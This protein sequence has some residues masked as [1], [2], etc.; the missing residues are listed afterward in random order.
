M[1]YTIWKEWVI[2]ISPLCS[3]GTKGRGGEANDHLQE[4]EKQ[5]IISQVIESGSAMREMQLIF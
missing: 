3:T 2:V 5:F 1:N 4:R